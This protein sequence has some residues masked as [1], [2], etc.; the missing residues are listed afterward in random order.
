M[1][2]G[3]ARRRWLAVPAVVD[4]AWR[5][6]AS[7]VLLYTFHFTVSWGPGKRSFRSLISLLILLCPNNPEG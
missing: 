1:D 6:A 4:L 5:F 3:H 7:A 2:N